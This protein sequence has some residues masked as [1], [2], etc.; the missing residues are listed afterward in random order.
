MMRAYNRQIIPKI[1]GITDKYY[2]NDIEKVSPTV[3]L[4]DKEIRQLIK[5]HRGSNDSVLVKTLVRSFGKYVV[6]I[7][8]NYQ[9]RGLTLSDLI[10]EGMLGLI[11]AIERFDLDNKTKFVTYSNTVI[12]RYM[13]EA[14]DYS[15][16]IV[17]IPKNIRNDK[18]KT[19][20]SI[21]SMQIRGA[22]EM[23]II[24]AIDERNY[25][26]L[27]NPDIYGRTSLVEPVGLNTDIVMADILESDE[28]S[29]DAKLNKIDMKKTIE[30]VLKVKLTKN[31]AKV[32][33]CFFG[34]SQP[35]PITVLRDIAKKL[36]L[37]KAE[38]K[39]FKD[40]AFQK[41]REEDSLKILSQY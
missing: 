2:I 12:S 25:Q 18:M 23:D 3:Y 6:S 11:K 39:S 28:K 1:K 21:N 14:L 30:N 33:R 4:N 37:T 8:K 7:A 35:Y 36:N 9:E 40:S 24:D 16:N 38:V 26:F 5:E 17:K 10:S 20:E 29:P 15:N 19:R 22:T 27:V 32:I 41:L 34:I 13:R 31:E